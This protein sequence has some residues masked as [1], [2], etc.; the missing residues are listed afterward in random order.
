MNGDIQI[1]QRIHCILYGGDDGTVYNIRGEQ[2]PETIKSIRG[3]VSMGGSASFDI[4]F[5]RGTISK[6][7]PESIVHGVQWRIFD[8]IA[9]DWEMVA[10]LAHAEQCE[11]Q[12]KREA[13]E[14][15]T[16]KGKEQSRISNGYPY[17][18][19]TKDTKMSSYALGAKNLGKELKRAFPGTKFSIRSKGYSMGCSI[20]LSW[21]DGPTEKAV[22]EISG[23]YQEGD[24]DGMEDIYNYD[25][26]NVWAPIYGGAKYVSE[27]RHYSKEL[28]EKVAARSGGGLWAIVWNQYGGWDCVGGR[29]YEY[30]ITKELSEETA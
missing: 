16:R 14:E 3:I 13:E 18:T 27:S 12:R 17:L 11:N 4:V 1:G 2:K 10:S 8:E 20:Y 15:E 25:H 21:T 5:D 6:G 19:K 26:S 22:Q 24:F 23:K 28:V 30:H 29:E 9:S 7:V